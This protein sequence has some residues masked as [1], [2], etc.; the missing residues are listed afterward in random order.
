MQRVALAAVAALALAG[1]ASAQEPG[2]RSQWTTLTEDNGRYL[3]L[4][5]PDAEEADLQLRCSS[6]RA[7]TVSFRVW[8]L[9]P[10]DGPPPRSVTVASGSTR[11]TAAMTF[12]PDELTADGFDGSL[13]LNSP[14]LAA[15]ARNG[16]LSFSVGRISVAGA[17]ATASERRA[18][19]GFLAGCGARR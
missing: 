12:R 2:V 10:G 7:G 3:T 5:Q 4:A 17:A 15:F 6:R 1:P 18:I 16:R 11:A 9:N 14:V 8:G 19:T 13:P